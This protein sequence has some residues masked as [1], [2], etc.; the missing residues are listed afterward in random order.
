MRNGAVLTYSEELT[1][2]R[3]NTIDSTVIHL[4]E[5]ILNKKNKNK[6]KIN[7]KCVFKYLKHQ[8]IMLWFANNAMSELMTLYKTVPLV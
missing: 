7:K 4:N 3:L 5:Y 1:M 8:T 6:I 2:F